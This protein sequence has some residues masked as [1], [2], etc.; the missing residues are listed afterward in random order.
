[1]VAQ[2]TS[3]ERNAV[4]AHEECTVGFVP[5]VYGTADTTN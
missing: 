5:L 1:M 3:K 4:R 2:V